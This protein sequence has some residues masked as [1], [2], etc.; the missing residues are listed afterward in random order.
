MPRGNRGNGRQ[1]T[2]E[3]KLVPFSLSLSLSLSLTLS[4]DDAQV[5]LIGLPESI[6]PLHRE[7]LFLR[8][9][10]MLS[11]TR[12]YC[13]VSSRA[14]SETIQ[15]HAIHTLRMSRPISAN[16][17]WSAGIGCCVFDRAIERE[18]GVTARLKMILEH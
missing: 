6:R 18:D 13:A 16:D 7:I 1:T 15:L 9:L 14:R 10:S 17:V 8:R 2:I 11:L 3:G 12:K 4:T 5:E